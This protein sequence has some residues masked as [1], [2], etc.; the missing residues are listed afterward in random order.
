MTT[1]QGR[2]RPPTTGRRVA[3]TRRARTR[4]SPLP[5]ITKIELAE[6][7]VAVGDAFVRTNGD[8]PISLQRYGAG[9][10]G[11]SFFS[12]NPPKG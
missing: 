12:K 3:R 5:G 6:Y 1:A 4:R 2:G 10:D 11:D 9:I 8:R 7:L